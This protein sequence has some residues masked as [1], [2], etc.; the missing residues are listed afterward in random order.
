MYDVKMPVHIGN[1]CVGLL[2]G[3]YIEPFTLMVV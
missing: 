3:K 2:D 1:L